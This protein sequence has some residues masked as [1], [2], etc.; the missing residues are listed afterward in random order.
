MRLNRDWSR[1]ATAG[2]GGGDGG[3]LRHAIGDQGQLQQVLATRGADST[4]DLGDAPAIV[5]GLKF[6]L[7][8]WHCVVLVAEDKLQALA[9]IET[10]SGQ[11]DIVITYRQLRSAAH[12][13]SCIA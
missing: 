6:L 1:R 13:G 11:P 10:W 5:S 8:S 2:A 4:I 9:A 12:G 7:R 3:W